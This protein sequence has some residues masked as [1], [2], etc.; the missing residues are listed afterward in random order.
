M[1]NPFASSPRKRI[2]PEFYQCGRC[3]IKSYHPEDI[4][5]RYCAKCKYFEGPEGQYEDG[6]RE[7]DKVNPVVLTCLHCDQPIQRSEVYAD[8][9][10]VHSDD[11]VHL[12]GRT[13]KYDHEPLPDVIDAVG[14]PV[15]DEQD[16]EA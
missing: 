9:Q 16:V 2:A 4:K 10:W 15:R 3:G 7:I 11:V 13:I 5:Q 8:N 12:K 6:P 1:S 14:K